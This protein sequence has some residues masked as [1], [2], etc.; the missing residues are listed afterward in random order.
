MGKARCVL[1][2]SRMGRLV[3]NGAMTKIDSTVPARKTIVFITFLQKVMGTE[4]QIHVC[5]LA[6]LQ[7]AAMVI[8]LF[9]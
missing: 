7:W 2:I 8:I 1:L 9:G 6:N 5:G 4:C 3:K